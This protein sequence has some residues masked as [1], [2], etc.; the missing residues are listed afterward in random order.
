[1]SNNIDQQ[2][3]AELG[4]L[5]RLLVHGLGMPFGDV[6]VV[7]KLGEEVEIR[8][9]H[10]ADEDQVAPCLVHRQISNFEVE[11]IRAE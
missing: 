7:E 1:M 11:D 4:L 5:L 2:E 6:G 8:E 10:D 3:C 9:V